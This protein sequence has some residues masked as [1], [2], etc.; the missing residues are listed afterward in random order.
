MSCFTIWLLLPFNERVKQLHG[1]QQNQAEPRCLSVKIISQ[2][3]TVQYNK[4]CKKS[5]SHDLQVKKNFKISE[6]MAQSLNAFILNWCGISPSFNHGIFYGVFSRLSC[7]STD[8]CC[9]SQS[10]C[11]TILNLLHKHHWLLPSSL[12]AY[13]H[14]MLVRS[15]SF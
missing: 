7:P 3:Q 15:G 1:R 6:L 10:G 12:F 11:S 14:V 2:C 13:L 4:C 5:F 8:C 9:L